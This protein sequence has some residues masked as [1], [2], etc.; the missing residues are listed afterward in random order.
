MQVL[1]SGSDPTDPVSAGT[2]TIL[3]GVVCRLLHKRT[4]LP[5]SAFIG[6]TSSLPVFIMKHYFSV[7]SRG[8]LID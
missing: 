1:L 8:I 5:P 3:G 6:A 2:T 7:S 4:D